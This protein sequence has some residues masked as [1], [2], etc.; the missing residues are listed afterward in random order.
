MKTIDEVDI[1]VAIGKAQKEIDILVREETEVI[2]QINWYV[3]EF[4][5]MSLKDGEDVEY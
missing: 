4:R 5:R 2:D 3:G 1:D